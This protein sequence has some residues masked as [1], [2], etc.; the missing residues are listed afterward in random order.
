MNERT[1]TPR[2]HTH[3]V[4]V[5]DSIVTTL[6][7]SL[8]RPNAEV[9]R[10]SEHPA[11]GNGDGHEKAPPALSDSQD[12]SAPR[13]APQQAATGGGV[14]V[15]G[16]GTDSGS[17]LVGGEA[18]TWSP[19]PGNHGPQAGQGGGEGSGPRPQAGVP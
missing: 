7:D 18:A 11:M 16:V 17:Y 3:D 15:P 2:R 14:A 1:S 9:R 10:A 5:S 6:D 13:P 4:R 19:Y 8:V 12:E